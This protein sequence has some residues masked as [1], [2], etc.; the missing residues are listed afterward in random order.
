LCL[1]SGSCDHMGGS[2]EPERNNRQDVGVFIRTAQ[3]YIQA[4]GEQ[5]SATRGCI[6]A[7]NPNKRMAPGAVSAR[8]P[9]HSPPRIL[10]LTGWHVSVSVGR[11]S[12]GLPSRGGHPPREGWQPPRKGSGLPRGG[13]AWYAWGGYRYTRG[14]DIPERGGARYTWGDVSPPGGMEP[15]TGVDVTLPHEGGRLPRKYE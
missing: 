6:R 7:T 5:I 10:L 3:A 12:S 13:E 15:G 9:R 11:R 14:R 2:R 1:P 8:P 4:T